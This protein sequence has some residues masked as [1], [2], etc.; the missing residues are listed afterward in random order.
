MIFTYRQEDKYKWQVQHTVYKLRSFFRS[1]T[2]EIL[3]K[4]KKNWINN[5]IQKSTYDEIL[6]MN[7]IFIYKL[8]MFYSKKSN[9]Q[10]VFLKTKIFLMYYYLTNNKKYL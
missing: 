2:T 9:F 4:N 6:G 3:K 10:K 1:T 7:T 8:Y 5:E